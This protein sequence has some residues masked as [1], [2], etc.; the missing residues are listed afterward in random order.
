MDISIGLSWEN[1]HVKNTFPLI[2][3]LHHCK[4]LH[5]ITWDHCTLTL[6]HTLH[7]TLADHTFTQHQWMLALQHT[8]TQH[9]WL[10]FVIHFNSLQNDNCF[11]FCLI[12]FIKTDSNKTSLISFCYWSQFFHMYVVVWHC[13]HTVFFCKTQFWLV[14]FFAWY[15]Y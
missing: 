5:T 8:L 14:W 10:N 2:T 13:I 4:F 1:F 6:T 15:T 9:H 7:C 11:S 3:T 12:T